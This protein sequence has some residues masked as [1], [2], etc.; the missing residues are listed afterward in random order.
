[1]ELITWLRL[2]ADRGAAVVLM[3]VGVVFVVLGWVGV[4]GEVYIAKQVP[5]VVSGG[6]GG[7][8]LLVVAGVL[9]LSADMNDEWHV[10]DQLDVQHSDLRREHQE[11]AL[12]LAAIEEQSMGKATAPN[13]HAP[14]ARTTRRSK[15]LEVS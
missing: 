8:A 5:F 13:G 12:R 2:H 1:M 11:L 9:W 10:L 14:V 4:S 7:L 6:I 3:V 15:T